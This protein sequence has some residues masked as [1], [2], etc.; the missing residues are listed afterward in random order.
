MRRKERKGEFERRR[1]KGP[2]EESQEEILPF[3]DGLITSAEQ[4]DQDLPPLKPSKAMSNQETD[5][6]ELDLSH[7]VSFHRISI[8]QLLQQ[9]ALIHTIFRH[10]TDTGALWEGL[11]EINL[12][13]AELIFIAFGFLPR[14]RGC[15]ELLDVWDALVEGGEVP[16]GGERGNFATEGLGGLEDGLGDE[17]AEGLPRAQGV[18]V[19]IGPKEL[20][21]FPD[22]YF[23]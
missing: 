17:A 16:Q 2:T 11:L 10:H 1:R 3:R 15:L 8:G 14:L 23:G 22:I 20:V 6:G 5:E 18:V 21:E 13:K 4:S 7:Q 9:P 19:G 12:G